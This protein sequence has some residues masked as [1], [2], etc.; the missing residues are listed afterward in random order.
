MDSVRPPPQDASRSALVP[1]MT[2]TLL[3]RL[4]ALAG[5]L[6]VV[7]CSDGGT[8]AGVAKDTGGADKGDAGESPS[9]TMQGVPAGLGK[10]CTSNADCKAYGL[11]CFL[12]DEQQGTGICSQVC[13]QAA[14]CGG[15]THC[16]PLSGVL[17]CTLP[18]YCNPCKQA[19]DCGPAA[20]I[21]VSKPGSGGPKFCSSNCHTGDGTCPPGASCVQ[22][23][24]MAKDFAC[25]PDYGSCDGGGEHC[26]PCKV[27]GDCQAGTLCLQ[28][29]DDTERFCA[30]ECAIGG[31]DVCPMDS[32]CTKHGEKA[33]CFKII[34]KDKEGK[35]VTYPTCAKGDKAFCDA[36]SAD[37]ECASKRC[38]TK[39]NEKFCAQ[40]GTCTKASEASDCPYGGQATF[41]VDSNKGM[42]CVPPLAYHCHGFK[43]CLH[44][45]CGAN[46]VCDNGIC[47]PK[48]P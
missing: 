7:G 30:T 48:A 37:Y 27:N 9:D 11:N 12:T 35:A 1:V 8:V 10:S 23:G 2:R 38:V 3:A 32:K 29:S 16:N 46:D 36:C 34:G 14:D 47:K 25:M 45:L 24:P 28:P 43:A 33:Y 44:A 31:P 5:L 21:C 6:C 20:P 18:R 15:N 41:C 40:A 26:S 42:V 19:S 4:A 39:N 13:K 22:Y 17:A